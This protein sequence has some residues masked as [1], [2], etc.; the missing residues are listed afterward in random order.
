MLAETNLTLGQP[1]FYGR[2]EFVQKDSKELDFYASGPNDQLLAM[3]FN[4]N[5]LTLGASYRLPNLGGARARTKRGRA[6][7]GLL[8]PARIAARPARRGLRGAGLR[9]AA[10]VGVS[11]RALECAVDA[12]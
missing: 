6:A 5:T 7:N 1:T 3:V 2:Y 10:S 11:I 12:Q 4:V 9:Q 8:H